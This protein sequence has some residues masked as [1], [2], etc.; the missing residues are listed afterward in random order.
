M[1][2]LTILITIIA[3]LL[4]LVVLVQNPKGGGLTGTFGGSATQIMGAAQSGNIM[5][6]ITWGLAVALLIL[7]LVSSLTVGNEGTQ[8]AGP[9]IETPTLP[10]Q[11]TGAPAGQPAGQQPAGGGQ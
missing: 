3:V 8:D 2:F 7:C 6:K 10:Q 11:P 4:V 1:L 5:E 9:Q